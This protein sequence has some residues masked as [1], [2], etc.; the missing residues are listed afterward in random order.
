VYGHTSEHQTMA[1]ES[2][3][4]VSMTKFDWQNYHEILGP[5]FAID[6]GIDTSRR[7]RL[8]LCTTML[9]RRW[10]SSRNQERGLAEG[11]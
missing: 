2:R 5:A 10:Y 7:A 4:H 3:N 9:V 8:A 11:S 1:N 6:P